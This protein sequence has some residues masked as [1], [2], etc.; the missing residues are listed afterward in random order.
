MN[1]DDEQMIEVVAHTATASNVNVDCGNGGNQNEHPQPNGP[2]AAILCWE[3]Q[4]MYGMYTSKIYKYISVADHRAMWLVNKSM[5]IAIQVCAP[6][7]PSSSLAVIF[8]TLM[9]SFKS[10]VHHFKF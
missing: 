8:I 2:F 5:R 4:S 7:L 9:Q 10:P 1:G 3:Q 6:T